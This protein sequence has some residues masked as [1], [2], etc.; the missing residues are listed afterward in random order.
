MLQAEVVKL[1]LQVADT[2]EALAKTLAL[3]ALQL[4]RNGHRLGILSK[5]AS[6]YAASER[7]W[8]D[9]HAPLLAKDDGNAA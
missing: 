1:A 5:A 2:E 7:Q 4:P 6:E 9:G 8:A 3:L